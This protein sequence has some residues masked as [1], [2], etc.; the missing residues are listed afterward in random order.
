MF[1]LGVCFYKGDGVKKDLVQACTYLKPLADEGDVQAQYFMGL[2][3]LKGLGVPQDYNQGKAYLQKA[4]NQGHKEAEQQLS[5][6]TGN[7]NPQLITSP[8][9]SLLQPVLPNMDEK[10]LIQ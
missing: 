5:I 7:S 6:A 9:K 2:C 10:C 3:F 1:N 4:A 8:S